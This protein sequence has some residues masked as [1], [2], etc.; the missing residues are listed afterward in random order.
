MIVFF[1]IKKL[2]FL[3]QLLLEIYM[4]KMFVL[5]SVL[6]FATSSLFAQD[7]KVNDHKEKF[8]WSF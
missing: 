4:K 3:K 2:F 7:A 1:T 8:D 6:L 5:I